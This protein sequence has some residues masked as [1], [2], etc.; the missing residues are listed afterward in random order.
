MSNNHKNNSIEF[1]LFSYFGLDLEDAKDFDTAL[2]KSIKKAYE[3]ATNQG[4]YNALFR[5]SKDDSKKN[6]YISDLKSKSD[7]I[8]PTAFDEIKSKIGDLLNGTIQEYSCWR[9]KLCDTIVGYYK[10]IKLNN[11]SLFTYGNA[12]KWINM[13]MKYLYIISG[14]LEDNKSQKWKVIDSLTNAYHIPIDNY[15]IESQWSNS[16]NKEADIPIPITYK[17]KCQDTIG[18]F[19]TT[20]YKSWSQ[21]D[22]KEYDDFQGVLIKKAASEHKAPIE[23]ECKT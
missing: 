12:Q 15:I 19:S 16:W 13:T 14:I 18:D 2:E 5:K 8:Y 7:N 3:D 20:K 4:A 21:W 10:G 6:K 22:Q 11:K 17:F 23:W 1:L 9:N